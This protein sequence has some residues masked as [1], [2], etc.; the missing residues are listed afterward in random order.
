MHENTILTQRGPFF[1]PKYKA[2]VNSQYFCKRKSNTWSSSLDQ[3]WLLQIQM[4]D[5]YGDLS[6]QMVIIAKS[7]GK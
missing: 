1:T 5:I 4:G 7:D 6:Q 2:C 3:I